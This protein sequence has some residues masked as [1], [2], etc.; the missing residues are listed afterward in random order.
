[1][2]ES[3]ETA[4]QAPASTH[5]TEGAVDLAIV[6]AGPCGIAVGAAA[7][8]AGLRAVL[9]DQGPLCASLVEYPYYMSFFS[10]PE[11]LEIE[12][13]PFVTSEK[14]GTRREALAYY[15]KVAEYFNLDVRQYQRVV[16]V[17]RKGEGFT[18]LTQTSTGRSERHRARNLV[19]A[20]GGFHGPN[21][22]QVPGEELSKVTHY[23]REAHPYWQRKVL[24]VGGSNSAVEAGL[25]LFRAGARVEMVHFARDFD[26][27]VKP[28]LLPDIRNRIQA[29]DIQ[30][31]WG[32]RVTEIQPESVLL[33]AEA[34]GA[35]TRRPNDHVLALT[36]WKASPVILQELGVPV[37]D[38]NGIPAHDEATMETPVPGV[39]I[40]GVLA[41]G[42]DANRI[43]IEN[44]RWHGRAIVEALKARD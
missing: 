38:T 20:T 14:T 40:A 28:W 35:L 33:R 5:P 16:G 36:G 24:V 26:K 7:R 29:E 4:R 2:T 15:R 10:T 17:E 42:H 31:W 37:D 3:H 23:Y 39:F 8:K 27:G 34:T 32:H 25:E 30:M 21:L 43:F 13:L 6:G 11:K 1:M 41:A 44:G 22:L 18:L 12:D 19:V 9:F